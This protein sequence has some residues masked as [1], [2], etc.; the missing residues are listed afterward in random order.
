M[1]TTGQRMWVGQAILGLLCVCLV[2]LAGRL[3][4]IQTQMR[5]ELL[6]WSQARQTSKIPLPG[7]RGHIF[8][9]RM[10]V[11]AGSHDQSTVF[12]D[13]LLVRDRDEL[14]TKLSPLLNLPARE[15]LRKIEEAKSSRYVVLRRGV[16]RG[17]VEALDEADLRGVGVTREP[18]R[19]YAMGS[20]A[21]HVLG[22]VGADGA[23]LEG[24]ELVCEKYL[25]CQPGQRVVYWD[26]RRQNAVFQDPE[27][28]VAPRNGLDVVLTIDA[29]IQEI[30]ERELDKTREK[31]K[32][33]AVMGIVMS[34]KT[35]EVL[36]LA[37]SP[38]YDPSQPGKV[39]HDVRRN[40]ILTDPME[41]GSIFKPFVLVGALDAGL[42]RSDEVLFCHNGLYVI[43]KRLLHDHHPYGNLTVEQVITK[44]S[45]I[46]MAILGQ[47]MG[48]ALMF[49]T[50]KSLGFGRRTGI[51]LPGE[52]LG[53]LS[54]LRRWNSYTTTSV[55]M[56]QEMA[57][58]PIQLATAFCALVN[59][60]RLP[61]PY[62]VAG[63]VDRT[64]K[65]IEDR[66]PED[67]FPQ[68]VNPAAAE[69]IKQI[70]IKTVNEG[71]GK[72]AQLEHWQVLGKT[73]TAQVPWDPEVRR[74]QRK[75]GY[76]PNAYL[77]SFLAAAPA[78]DPEVVILVM[79]RKPDRRIGYYGGTVAAPAVKAILQETLAYLNVPPDKMP[80]AVSANRLA[81]D[82]GRD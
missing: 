25:R 78:S 39:S 41:P 44:S 77:G 2:A 21:A 31:Y 33:E 35:G 28:Y 64:G 68:V 43:G 22:F 16:D 66:R 62:V 65:V 60:G 8:D 6:A 45:N 47:R 15:I 4:Y 12:V 74:T 37:I 17:T 71:T 20:L 54:P 32:A 53:L 48:N 73:G 72:P 3:T 5:L 18:A 75:K 63:V 80:N 36:S 38:R 81:T 13:P 42:T 14:A 49:E 58:T 55:P 27:G 69:T 76:E 57:L 52:D 30:V 67:E 9:R 19:V 24:V 34:P 61:R 40:R 7:Q 56:G 1:K 23:G 79:V 59:G 46:G 82:L 29:A 50:L 26:A 70:L 11:L 10:R 51:D